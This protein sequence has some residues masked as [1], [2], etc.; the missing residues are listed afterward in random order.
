MLGQRQFALDSNRDD[1]A[2]RL[3][4]CH[5]SQ[6][7][8][9]GTGMLELRHKVNREQQ[10]K[11]DHAAKCYFT[12]LLL[13]KVVAGN[14]LQLWCQGA[15]L[16]LAYDSI[17][18]QGRAKV[19]LSMVLSFVMAFVRCHAAAGNI[20]CLGYVILLF[21]VLFAMWVGARTFHVFVCQDHVWNL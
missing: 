21:V 17:G 16:A 5:E 7:G 1:A 15:F 3:R 12:M 18:T 8:Y 10:E 6:T 13:L 11:R 2:L 4:A 14:C 20:G 19:M 9:A